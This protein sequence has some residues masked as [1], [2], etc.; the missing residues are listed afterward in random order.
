L[1]PLMC[2]WAVWFY[3]WRRL[4]MKPFSGL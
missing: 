2:F 1:L 3:I 4:L